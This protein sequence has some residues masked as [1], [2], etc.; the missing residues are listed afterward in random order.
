MSSPWRSC[1]CWSPAS[2]WAGWS[3]A[4][5]SRSVRQ[6]ADMSDFVNGAVVFGLVTIGGLLISLYGILSGQFRYNQEHPKSRRLR[7][8]FNFRVIQ[9]QERDQQEYVAQHIAGLSAAGR[10]NVK[11]LSL[12]PLLWVLF[13]CLLTP[14]SPTDFV[15]WP[16]LLGAVAGS[17]P[18]YLI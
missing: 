12:S 7:D 17:L 10:R 18:P 3:T 1:S 9:Q 13:V 2:R 16:A 14:L 6:V 15:W 8:M 4:R 5:A 11:T